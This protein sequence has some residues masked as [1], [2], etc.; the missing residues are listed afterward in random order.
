MDGFHIELKDIFHHV[1]GVNNKLAGSKVESD[2]AL[3]K[4][5]E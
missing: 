2:F 5:L 1:C 4:S 3:I